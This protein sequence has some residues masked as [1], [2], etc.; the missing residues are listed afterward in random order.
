[1]P[2]DLLVNTTPLPN[3]VDHI[4]EVL[5]HGEAILGSIGYIACDAPAS[6]IVPDKAVRVEWAGAI[7][8]AK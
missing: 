5:Q 6:V 2:G 7:V 4:V 3:Y 8:P 1:M